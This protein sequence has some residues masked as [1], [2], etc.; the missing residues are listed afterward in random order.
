LFGIFAD[1]W[2]FI[3]LKVALF[4]TVQNQ[5]LKK[6]PVKKYHF[7]SDPTLY[8]P[9]MYFYIIFFKFQFHKLQLP[10]IIRN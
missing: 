7:L 5:K 8:L 6:F 9:K 10:F 3:D 1:F 4:G 2:H